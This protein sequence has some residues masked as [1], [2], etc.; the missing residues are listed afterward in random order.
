MRASLPRILIVGLLFL[1]LSGC[2]ASTASRETVSMPNAENPEYLTNPFRLAALPLHLA[3]NILQYGL[4]EPF[5]FALSAFPDAV[6]LSIEE[7][8]YL[9]QRKEAW[10]AYRPTP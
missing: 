4:V 1:A 7:Q 2:A 3:G 10:Q 5:Y 9:A 6:G 8:R